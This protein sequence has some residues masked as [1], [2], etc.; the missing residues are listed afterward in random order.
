M[1]KFNWNWLNL[2]TGLF[3]I[4]YINLTILVAHTFHPNLLVNINL[5]LNKIT[6]NFIS[7][8]FSNISYE[9][10]VSLYWF[11]FYLIGG[12]CLIFFYRLYLYILDKL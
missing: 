11:Y 7:N 3:V 8:T 4:T 10:I 5:L 2:G 9:M 1:I 12:C 6:N